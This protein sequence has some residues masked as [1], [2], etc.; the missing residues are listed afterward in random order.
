MRLSVIG[1]GKLGAP[2]AALLA[3]AGHEVI[4]LDVDQHAVESLS[5]GQAPVDEPGLQD[6]LD[7]LA[8]PIATTANP[9]EAFAGCDAT[10]VVVPT[11]SLEDGTFSL[12]YVLSSVAAIGESLRSSTR[13]HTT[14]ITSTVLPGS[15]EGPI[16][17]ALEK[18]SGRRVR[19]GDLGLCYSPEFIALGSVIRDMTQPDF[20]LIGESH[21]Q[22][23]ALIEKISATVCTNSPPVRHMNLVNAELAKIAVNTFVTTKISYANMLSEMCDQLPGADVDSVTAAIG[24]DSRIGPKY[25]TGATAYGGPCFPRDNLAFSA[26]GRQLG[27]SADLAEATDRVNVRQ[28]NRL[29]SLV[30]ANFGAASRVGILGLAYKAGTSVIETSTGVDLA[31]ALAEKGIRPLVWDPHAVPAATRLLSSAVDYAGSLEEVARCDIIVIA[32]P[33]HE[34]EDLSRQDVHHAVVIDCWRQLSATVDAKLV[35]HLGKGPRGNGN[36]LEV[37][38]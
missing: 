15:T 2:F 16:R 38:E 10:F 28:S 1:L 27:M 35:V 34:F 25:L 21:P 24:L 20:V 33:W 19:E 6:L 32:T 30:L 17:A 7:G 9:T 31:R 14:V 23:G 26:L 5:R 11:P 13:P 37:P 3:A 18:S 29:V 22:A 8:K 4:G 36:R 12:E